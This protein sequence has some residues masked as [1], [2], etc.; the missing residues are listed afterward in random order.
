MTP[1]SVVVVKIGGGEGVDPAPV[2]Q[3]LAAL[4]RPPPNASAP[5]LRFVVVHGTSDAAT[6]L[7]KALGREPRF[8]TSVSGHTSRFTDAADMEI[9]T[10]A[11]AGYNASL[12]GRLQA[13]GVD[14]VGLTGLDGRLLSGRRKDSIRAVVDGKQVVV[15]GDHSGVVERV[16]ARLLR[17][18]LDAGHVPVVTLPALA[19]D[20]TAVNVD[21]DR[22]GAAVAGALG[23]A[24]YVILT[25]VPGLLRDKADPASLVR[26]VP[27]ELMAE[28]ERLAEGR[29]KKKVLAAR[30]ALAGGVARVVV[31]GTAVERPVSAALAGEGTVFGPASAREV[32]AGTI[33]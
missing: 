12:V 4:L 6:R 14:A 25:N 11:A 2:L 7:Q 18:L 9:V 20:G 5:R 22:A 30:E 15:R 17:T 16:N 13:L 19:D 26:E 3:D 21:A 28:A 23:A 32:P 33:R 8:V 10:M 1:T 29:F 24:A 27:P 31:A